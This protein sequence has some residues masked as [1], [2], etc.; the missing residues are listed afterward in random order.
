MQ[1]P[2]HPGLAH[3][4]RHYLV[5][6]GVSSAASVHRLFADGNTG[7]VFNFDQAAQH[8][9]WVYGQVHTFH[10]LSLTGRIN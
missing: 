9:C 10:D 3:L 4:I 1:L 6:D 5:L 7:V 2:P 8:T